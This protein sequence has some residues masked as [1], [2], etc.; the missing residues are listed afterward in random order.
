MA[1]DL[2]ITYNDVALSSED[3]V[4]SGSYIELLDGETVIDS[5]LVILKGD[6]NGTGGVNASDYLEI[7]KYFKS[8][9]KA[10][11]EVKGNC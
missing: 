9:T 8:L 5:V 11:Q 6:V 10:N 2:R 7:K 3:L 1:S 4:P